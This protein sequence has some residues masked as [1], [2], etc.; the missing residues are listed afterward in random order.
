MLAESHCSGLVGKSLTDFN[1]SV[2]EEED[3]IALYISIHDIFA[4]EILKSLSNLLLSIT[5]FEVVES[6]SAKYWP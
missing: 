6:S 1:G 3:V 2:T 5:Y 4:V